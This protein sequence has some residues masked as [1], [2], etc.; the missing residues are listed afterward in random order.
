M[1]RPIKQT[2]VRW[3]RRD[4]VPKSGFRW[5]MI[6][7]YGALVVSVCA[8]LISF[9][10]LY[11]SHYGGPQDFRVTINLPTG[12]ARAS[13]YVLSDSVLVDPSKITE[14]FV[15]DDD[16]KSYNLQMSGDM[17]FINVGSA[18]ILV[19]DVSVILPDQREKYTSCESLNSY[20]S[21]SW[22][23]A[24]IVVAPGQILPTKVHFTI[25]TKLR[26]NENSCLGFTLVDRSGDETRVKVSGVAFSRG[27]PV[28]FAI[29]TDGVFVQHHALLQSVF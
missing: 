6:K 21:I 12:F 17:S 9:F 14:N 16:A 13:D 23:N 3:K 11:I 4:V 28:N 5:A 1:K 2:V 24:P 22:T 8:L 26:L 19:S 18:P 10:S 25:R 29:P 7:N 15:R 20:A 27:G